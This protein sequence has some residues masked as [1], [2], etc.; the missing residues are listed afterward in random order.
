MKIAILGAGVIGNALA[1][2]LVQLGHQ[3]MMGSRFGCACGPLSAIRV[4]TSRLCV[5]VDAAE[6]LA[7]P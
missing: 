4:S 5:A 3:I 2:K 6:P 1:T 7:C